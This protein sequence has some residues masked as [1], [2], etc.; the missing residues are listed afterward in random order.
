MITLVTN[1]QII[2]V[3]MVSMDSIVSGTHGLSR[4]VR[5]SASLVT[6][7]VASI[8]VSSVI[9]RVSRISAIVQKIPHVIHHMHSTNETAVWI[10]P[11][12]PYEHVIHPF[13]RARDTPSLLFPLIVFSCFDDR[14][15]PNRCLLP[16]VFFF[17]VV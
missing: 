8:W 4:I 6:L 5:I 16:L 14:C 3:L 12:L 9:V 2:I 15:H 10:Y 17:H 11:V 13:L 1:A 7:K